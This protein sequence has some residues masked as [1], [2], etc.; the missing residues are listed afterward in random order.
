MMADFPDRTERSPQGRG[1]IRRALPALGL[2]AAAISGYTS[3]SGSNAQDLSPPDIAPL[4]NIPMIIQDATL[5]HFARA[6]GIGDGLREIM[7]KLPDSLDLSLRDAG[8]IVDAGRTERTAYRID[9]AYSAGYLDGVEGRWEADRLDR[10]LD[11]VFRA[12]VG[13]QE[14]ADQ[15]TLRW[16]EEIGLDGGRA[17]VTGVMAL[18]VASDPLD[19]VQPRLGKNEPGLDVAFTEISRETGKLLEALDLAAYV[20][21]VSGIGVTSWPGD[22][23]SVEADTFHLFSTTSEPEFLP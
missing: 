20:I 15:A 13:L 5:L 17:L 11:A 7:G 6:Q 19:P 23:F 2:V 18:T 21:P 4:T 8:E 12:E 1:A 22:G 14:L 16:A 9:M 10:Y 3:Q